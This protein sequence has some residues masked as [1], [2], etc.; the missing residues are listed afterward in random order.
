MICLLILA[1]G[2]AVAI[3][4]GLILLLPVALFGGFIICLVIPVPF[5]CLWIP[6]HFWWRRRKCPEKPK[7]C[8]QSDSED[9]KLKWN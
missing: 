8:P 4:L 5:L 2:A 9:E 1:G 3:V 7:Y 6:Y